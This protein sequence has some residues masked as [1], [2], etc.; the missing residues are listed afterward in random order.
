MKRVGIIG[1]G[2]ISRIYL[3]NLTG[4][5]KDRLEI[6]G[7]CDYFYEKAKTRSM[8]YNINKIYETGEEMFSDPSVD[9]I[10]NLTRPSE[11]FYIS[12]A[13]LKAGK[14][15]YSEKPL[16]ITFEEG[17]K[18]NEL[19]KEKGLL[20][21][22]APDTF[23]GAGMQTCIRLIDEGLIGDVIGTSAFLVCRGHESWHPDPEFYYKKG[24][25][26]MM[27]MGPYYIS[28]LI[29][30]IGAIK[31]VTGV[32]KTSFPT[33]T[34]TSEKKHGTIIDVDVP[35]HVTGILEFNQGAIGTILTTF[36]VFTAQVP[37][38]EIYGSKSTLSVP[39]PNTF[40]GPVKL[41]N[42]DTNVFDDI[43]IR[44]DYSEDS[45]GLGLYDMVKHIEDGTP[46]RA[47]G[48]LHLHV[49]E[50]M[51]GFEKAYKN[52]SFTDMKTSPKRPVPMRYN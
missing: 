2:D 50:V 34:I 39:D 6:A 52:K 40:C 14:H 27:D 47:S 7:L 1:C 33:R 30:M 12:E 3:Q 49:L 22:G 43:P 48:E 4:L 44:T 42:T 41:Y 26:P 45:R 15:V 16:G 13:A 8:E 18:L 31:T 24:G 29:S 19:A 51:S 17:Y 37:R 32:T 38:I 5:F 25:G 35:T 21:G 23:L 10:L 11:H 20:I 9:I 46:F 28:A 36:D